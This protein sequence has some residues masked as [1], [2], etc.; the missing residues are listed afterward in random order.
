MTDMINVAAENLEGLAL[1]WA[2][3]IADG[4]TLEL[5]SAVQGRT[6]VVW[7]DPFVVK[8]EGRP[9][10]HDKTYRHW[11]PSTNWE[12]CGPLIDKYGNSVDRVIDGDPEFDDEV[13]AGYAWRSMPGDGGYWMDGPTALVA[14]CRAIVA[15]K[16]GLLISVPAELVQQ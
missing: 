6:K 16:L 7:L 14:I 11:A 3:G 15:A 13:E 2:V 12:Q 9:D 1:D 4:R 8:L 10:F 5:P